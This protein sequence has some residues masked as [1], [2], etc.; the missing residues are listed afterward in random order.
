MVERIYNF[1]E[2]FAQDLAEEKILLL[3]NGFSIGIDR[4]FSYNHLYDTFS[5]KKA[6]AEIK[7]TFETL[8]SANFEDIMSAILNSYSIVEILE[9]SSRCHLNP[10]KHLAN[11]RTG[12]IETLINIHQTGLND[13]V[14]N[15]IHQT[16]LSKFEKIFTTNYDLHLY[17]L[18]QY[19]G[20]GEGPFRDGFARYNQNLV[21]PSKHTASQNVF[22][23]HGALHLIPAGNEI[24][25]TA[26][27][28]KLSGK[29]I[30]IFE[31]AQ[32]L[33]ENNIYPLFL[34]EATSPCKFKAIARS[35]YLGYCF[36]QLKQI[37]NNANTTSVWMHGFS[38]NENDNHIYNAIFGEDVI[39]SV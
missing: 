29:K 23:L 20:D 2:L 35:Y 8:E 14:K 37:G 15:H 30:P 1:K 9:S 7:A 24:D 6:S 3:G 10:E 21:W 4:N 11:I 28:T 32:Q 22:F 18:I 19:Q 12:F 27:L 31:Q 33:A 34:L 13:E 39:L 17:W 26:Y 25:G 5:L 38:F 36:E 16:F